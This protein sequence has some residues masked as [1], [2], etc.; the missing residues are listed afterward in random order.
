MINKSVIFIG[1][2]V[3]EIIG[4]FFSDSL[5]AFGIFFGIIVGATSVQPL[6]IGVAMRE[7]VTDI[8]LF[9]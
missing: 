7:I 5:G 9:F 6:L 2:V 8:F 1:A 3:G 4:F